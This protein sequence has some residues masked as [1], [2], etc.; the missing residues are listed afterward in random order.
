MWKIQGIQITVNCKSE[1]VN[2]IGQALTLSGI[3]GDHRREKR[4]QKGLGKRFR[5][6]TAKNVTQS[7]NKTLR[8]R[9]FGTATGQFCRKNPQYLI[10]SILVFRTSWNETL[11]VDSN[12]TNA[13]HMSQRISSG[14]RTYNTRA[15]Q[16]NTKTIQQLSPILVEG[17][18]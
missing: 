9:R 16:P 13:K 5:L 4:Y 12:H 11:N 6:K 14:Q 18:T 1:N 10:N 15:V 8:T 2:S 17:Q 3:P 7:V